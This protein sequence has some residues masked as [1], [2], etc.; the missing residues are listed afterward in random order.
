[1]GT[2]SPV[3]APSQIFIIMPINIRNEPQLTSVTIMMNEVTQAIRENL[4][5]IDPVAWFLPTMP[6]DNISFPQTI[7]G[8]TETSILMTAT[9][10][11]PFPCYSF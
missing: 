10:Q 5:T 11:R 7:T 3:A 9:G 6:A 1:V 8:V 4:L 2:K